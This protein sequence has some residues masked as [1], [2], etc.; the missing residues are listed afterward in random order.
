MI[1]RSDKAKQLLNDD[2]TSLSSTTDEGAQSLVED[3]GNLV[4]VVV[5]GIDVVQQV[6]DR[7]NARDRGALG[8]KVSDAREQVRVLTK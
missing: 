8:Q 3:N 6:Q 1:L 4:D 7:E 2:L 5:E